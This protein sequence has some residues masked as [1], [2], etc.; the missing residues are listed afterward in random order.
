MTI[1]W[2]VTP[3]ALLKDG[4]GC[5]RGIDGTVTESWIPKRVPAPFRPQHISH[6][7]PWR[8]NCC[9]GGENRR[10]S[11]WATAPLISIVSVNRQKKQQ[12]LRKRSLSRYWSLCWNTTKTTQLF[13]KE[14]HPRCACKTYICWKKSITQLDIRRMYILDINQRHVSADSWPSSGWLS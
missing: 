8:I 14:C 9:I 13:F 2:L 10:L 1:Y 12:K 6:T 5:A 4:V 11:A 7:L 3:V